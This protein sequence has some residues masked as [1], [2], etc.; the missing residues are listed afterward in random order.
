MKNLIARELLRVNGN[1]RS[2]DVLGAKLRIRSPIH[3]VP[4]S[5]LATQLCQGVLPASVAGRLLKRYTF[6]T[7]H[8]LL[9]L[10]STMHSTGKHTMKHMIV[11]LLAFTLLQCSLVADDWDANDDTFDPSIQS[12]VIGNAT[13]LGD[14]S[15]FV[16]TELAR[17]GYTYVSPVA[18]QGFEPSLQISLMVPL[19]AGETTPPAGGMLLLDKTQALEFIKVFESGIKA[20]PKDR[21]Q[22]I[23]IKT[24]MKEADWALTFDH[25]KDQ[26]FLQFEN[27]NKSK[28][29][30]Y[31][32]TI[33]ASKKLLGAIKHSL[34]KL[35]AKTDK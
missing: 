19:A 10:L 6:R 2:R 5:Q 14:P 12:V 17:T 26:R 20:E 1:N 7:T 25:E 27:K 30:K 34:E 35:E 15:P 11:C 8:P 28:V 24:G 21:D 18:Y 16:H 33:N 29:D 4:T 32:F 22:R 23:Q 31:R 3:Y 9:M 13:W